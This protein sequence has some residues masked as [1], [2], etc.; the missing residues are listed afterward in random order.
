MPELTTRRELKSLVKSGYDLQKLRIMVGLRLVA[1]FKVKLGQA[2]QHSEDELEAEEKEILGVLRL[3]YERLTDG[4][5]D[6][7]LTPAKFKGDE[8]ITSFAELLLV[9]H[10]LALLRDEERIFATFKLLVEDFPIWGAFL[11]DLRGIGPAMAAVLIAYYDIHK[12]YY[13]TQM[14]SYAGL[15]VA[16]DGR[17]RSKR[18]EHLIKRK[19]INREG[20]EAERNSITYEPFLHDK[21]LGTLAVIFLRCDSPYKKVYDQYKHRLQTDPRKEDWTKGHIHRAA[22]RYMIKIFILDLY[23]EWRAVEGLEIALP[24]HEAKLGLVHGQA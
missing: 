3:A 12:A 13:P 21:L 16:E 17:A 22:L 1:N 9:R 23:K 20:E 4:V 5:L 11:R 14:W 10:Y 6:K 15:D 8:I 2:P 24:Y 7:S 19:Y 18:K